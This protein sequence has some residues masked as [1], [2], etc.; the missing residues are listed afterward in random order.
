MTFIKIYDNAESDRLQILSDNNGKS[1][2]Y[3]WINKINNKSYIGSG[4]DLG[5]ISKGRLNRYY[6]PSYLIK[7]SKTLIKDAIK[8]TTTI[9]MVVAHSYITVSWL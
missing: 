3:I 7:G 8:N 1:G 6:I 4:K 2:I 9:I 5:N